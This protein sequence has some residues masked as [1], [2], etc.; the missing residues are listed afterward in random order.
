MKGVVNATDRENKY[1]QR[2]KIEKNLGDATE[3]NY[4]C[5]ETDGIKMGE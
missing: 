2:K 3:R 4:N 5:G 1:E